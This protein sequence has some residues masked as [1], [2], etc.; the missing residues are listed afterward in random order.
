MAVRGTP[1]QAALEELVNLTGISLVYSSDVVEGRTTVCRRDSV[2]AAVLLRCI[3]EGAGLD[4]Y[5]LSSGTFVVIEAPEAEPAYGRVSGRVVDAVTGAPVPMAT[6]QGLGGSVRTLTDDRGR[7]VLNRLL[8]GSLEL[9]VG[10]FGYA[11]RSLPI[12]L[13]PSESLRREVRLDPAVIEL[14]PVVVDG[15]RPEERFTGGLEGTEPRTVLTGPVDRSPALRSSIGLA[16]RPLFSEL[17]LQ[18]G[19]PGEHMLRLD[20]APVY[21]PVSLGRSRSAFSPIALRSIRVRKAGFGVEQGSFSGGLID[22]E[23]ALADPTGPGGVTLLADPW[24]TNASASVPLQAGEGAGSIMVAGRRSNWDLFREPSLDEAMQEWNRVDPI[25]M[26][27]LLGNATSASDLLPYTLHG[28]GADVGFSDLHAVL[29]LDFP[30]FTRFGASFYDGSNRFG[31]ELFASGAPEGSTVLERLA[32]VGESYDWSNRMAQAYV[33]WLVGDRLSLRAQ[34][35]FSE[36]TLRHDYAMV[37]GSEVGYDPMTSEIPAVE[38]A[39]RT[40]LASR[41]STGEGN[42]IE[43]VG[44]RLDGDVVAGRDHVLSTGFE[45]L[46]VSSRVQLDNDLV[47]ALATDIDAW[48]ASAFVGDRWRLSRTV[49]V[50]GGVRGTV[51]EDAGAFLEPRGSIRLDGGSDQVQWSARAAAGVYRQFVDQF[52]LTNV[53]PSALVPSL[54]FWIPS[55]GTVDPARSRHLSVEGAA[56]L[57][58]GWEFR[59]EAY[60]KTLDQLPTLDYGALTANR[61]GDVVNVDQADFV[62][63]AEGVAY[64]LGARV[65]WG[66]D[67]ARA[68]IGYDWSVSERTSPSRFGGERQPTP[69]NEPHRWTAAGQLPVYG[70]WAIDTSL[71]A[72]LGRSWALRRAYYDFLSF[73]DQEGLPVVGR[74]GDDRLPTLYRADIGASWVGRVGAAPAE[75]RLEVLNLQHRQVLDYSLVED[76]SA[77]DG[78]RRT[79]RLLPGTTLLLS[80]RVGL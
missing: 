13:G 22:V 3:V 44:V 73:H 65:G 20:G 19:A 57:A 10:G 29:R 7:F 34:S 31:S 5:M 18:G 33:D 1:V 40:E 53:G 17:S 32:V 27:S 78:Y 80:V 51:I 64:G 70:G 66:V 8:P 24:S 59:A 49:T 79:P 2:P 41:P 45:V 14:G 48:R 26:G 46:R 28:H 16:R 60:H 67:R 4:F 25:L 62:G 75:F 36:H 11:A 55:D 37:D 69:W 61:G 68:E 72:V 15:I 43:E 39:L 77:A 58:D 42:N 63:S 12:R 21:D 54:R 30:G 50:E 23:H 56:R 71:S 6:I 35:W 76:A 74:P 9:T 47:T 38:T 52:E